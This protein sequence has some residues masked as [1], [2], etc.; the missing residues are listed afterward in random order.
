M[1]QRW[2]YIGREFPFFPTSIES[3]SSFEISM[4]VEEIGYRNGLNVQNVEI[5]IWKAMIVDVAPRKIESKR[6]GNLGRKSKRIW[7]KIYRESL[8]ERIGREIG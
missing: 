3:N 7:E 2:M 8:I 1:I 4:Q 6:S 5:F